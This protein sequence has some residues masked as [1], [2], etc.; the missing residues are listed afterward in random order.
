MNKMKYLLSSILFCFSTLL[1][2]QTESLLV[3]GNV[4]SEL[5]GGLIGVQV[6]EID[7][8]D[9]AISAT[10]TDF[11]GNFSLQ[12]KNPNNKLRMT[13][14]GFESVNLPIGSRR[15]F[16]VELKENT[17][18]AEVVIT[19]QAVHND[20]TF[21]IPK[22][23]ISGAV[24]KLNTSEF[25][26]V[27]VASIDDA[28]QGRIAGLDIVGN[29]G[30]LGSGST[31]RIRGTS[32]INSNSEPLIV[33][34]DVP[35]ESNISAFD[36]ANS[37]TEQFAN[38]L[39]L[40]PDDIEE[41]TVLKD[42]ASAAIWGSRGANGVINIRTK[43]GAK[44]PTRV[45][46]VYRFS[47]KQQ[48]KGLSML[49]GDDYTMMMKQA[50]F[51][52]R[53]DENAANLLEFNYDPTFSEYENFNNN[54]DWVDAISQYGFGHD[55][56]V[57]VSGGG[58]KANFRLS[59]GY[60]TESGTIIKQ[61]M[62]RITSR[63]TFEYRVS[64]RIRFSPEFAFTYTNNHKNL[65]DDV[66]DGWNTDNLLNMAY[67]KMPN[68]SIYQQDANGID[69]D[70]FY[71]IRQLSAETAGRAV[72][73]ASQQQLW[74]PVALAHLG[75][76]DNKSLRIMPK[77]SLRYDILDPETAML[78]YNGYVSFD[79][80]SQ[81]DMRF[82]PREVVSRYDD[83]TRMSIQ[84]DNYRRKINRSYGLEQEALSI[85][86]D[87]NLTYSPAL[88]EKQNLLLYASWQFMIS[89]SRK[90]ELQ[91]YG[92]ASQITTDPTLP[93][94]D[95][96]FKS[97][98]GE[99]KTMGLLGRVH[100]AY[101][102][103]YIIDLSIRRDADTRF[104][105]NN[106][107]GNF[108][109]ASVKWILSDEWFMEST[110][111]WLSEFGIRG[112]YGVVGTP[113]EYDYLYFS[114]Y[115]GDWGYSNAYIDI[116]TVKPKSIQLSNLKW[117]TSTSYNAGFDLSLFDF[118]YTV[119]FNTYKKRTKDLLLKS[120]S[121]PN[122]TGFQSLD[123]VNA[124][125]LDNSGWEVYFTTT[126]MI[127]TNNWTF[128][129][130]FNLSNNVNQFASLDPKFASAYNKDFNY[131]NGAY[132]SRI[133]EGNAIGSIYGFRYKGV[134][135]YDKYEEGREGTSPYARNAE[136]GVILDSNGKPVPMYFAYGTTSSYIFR[137][138]DA[139]YEDINHDGSIDELDI[140]YLGN[141]NPK[142]N[143]GFGGTLRYKNFSVNAF[144]NFRYG[145]KI[146]NMARMSAE[147]MYTNDNQSI[148]VNWRW[149]K[150]GD[151]T[152]MPRALYQEGYNWLPSDRFV[153]DGSFLRFKY[154]TFSY[155]FDKKDVQVLKIN[156]LDLYLTLNNL[157]T[158]TKYAGVDP[159]ISPNIRPDSGLVGV[160]EDKSRT[161][162][163]QYFTLGVTV[164]F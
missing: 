13:Y 49:N 118:K 16:D 67:R 53:Q 12:I 48:P 94:Q 7:K 50:Y 143:G 120:L 42:G 71:T 51:N 153:E 122:S 18:L 117:E 62:E 106:R 145:N 10:V 57:T 21:A 149:R 78:R 147:N 55:H 83:D 110:K 99:R 164:G 125:V 28:L 141:S 60:L 133:Q 136:G 126:N 38:L 30:N 142:L 74:N 70:M 20:G 79:Y 43:K 105:P 85:Y 114:R 26:G 63:M 2:G 95:Q 108:P 81:N 124:G 98:M 148:A 107:W 6:L 40:N 102:S 68:V 93:G 11:S 31:L 111:S 101:D 91:R 86:S 32:S 156:Q 44:G 1:F 152:E 82:L 34:N 140:V 58:D 127:K 159:E 65:A 37:N 121:I 66:S 59:F 135:Q 90:Q 15:K 89:N 128:D 5:D 25:K 17:T 130:N 80:D 157:Y 96:D 39:N 14:V 76:N 27:S 162:R 88:G 46:Y 144:F 92:L 158:W 113:P 22:R 3:T 129:F 69:T 45:Q 163:S 115:D 123:Y 103:R 116:P 4:Y 150:D 75:L 29:S 72:L 84:N 36:F 161:P 100:Y 112:G 137:G 138:G 52:P 154:L 134:Y 77:F 9:R 33:V 54:T 8:T 132:L 73:N 151:L 61:D 155:N 146:L 19:A 104:G 35:F 41:I 160:S 23:E 56:N 139:I 64:D 47:G 109:A 87:Q 24:Q 97:N 119:E 131:Q